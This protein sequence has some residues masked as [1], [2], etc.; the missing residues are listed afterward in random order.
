MK[1]SSETIYHVG[2]D[3]LESETKK[4]DFQVLKGHFQEKGFYMITNNNGLQAKI[5]N[6]YLAYFLVALKNKPALNKTTMEEVL[7]SGLDFWDAYFEGYKNGAKYF[8]ENYN[9]KP[10]TI[11]D[12]A[13]FFIKDLHYLYYHKEVNSYKGWSYYVKN[14]APDL[15]ISKAQITKY[16][17]YAALVD[18]V[19]QLKLKYPELFKG[20]DKC[21][22]D[23]RSNPDQ[24]DL[25]P[26]IDNSLKNTILPINTNQ[27]VLK[28]TNKKG[29]LEYLNHSDKEKLAEELKN[30]FTTE[31]G[32]DIKILIK[33][34]EDFE[35]I[36]LGSRDLKSFIL[37]MEAYFEREIPYESVRKFKIEDAYK[38]DIEAIKKRVEIIIRDVKNKRNEL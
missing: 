19:D 37:A 35:L 18:R 25:N 27:K 15:I 26:P 21:Y 34:L 5:Y 8:N 33:V 1:E 4:S 14:T 22:H 36:K 9:L 28:A 20:F 10:N 7:I 2:I 30:K 12:K 38:P 13:Q 32:K 6:L 17:Y 11:Y 29:F 16:G 31:K 23:H 3:F 24:K